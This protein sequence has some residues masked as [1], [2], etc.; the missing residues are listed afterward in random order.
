MLEMTMLKIINCH[1][2]TMT[3]V[4]IM[5]AASPA[6]IGDT[7]YPEAVAIDCVQLF[8]RMVKSSIIPIRAMIL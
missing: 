2:G 7:M 3:P 1:Q 5:Y 4:T 6:T 8:S